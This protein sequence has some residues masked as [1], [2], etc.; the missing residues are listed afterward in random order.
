MQYTVIHY[1][2]ASMVLTGQLHFTVIYNLAIF[3]LLHFGRKLGAIAKNFCQNCFLFDRHWMDG[4]PT[5]EDR[6][7]EFLALKFSFSEKATKICTICL[8]WYSN[9]CELFQKMQS[10]IRNI[11]LIANN[12]SIQY[13]WFGFIKFSFSEKTTKI[14]LICLLV[15]TF[16]K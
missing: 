3:I 7:V 5:R 9:Y 1:R 16:T 13:S 10:K 14:C 2:D 8:V 11:Y 4:C 15:L 12:L 6:I